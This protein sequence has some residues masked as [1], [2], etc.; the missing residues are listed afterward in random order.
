MLALGFSQHSRLVKA[1]VEVRVQM[2]GLMRK[3]RTERSAIG[4]EA[5]VP[6]VY[7][8]AVGDR[9]GD[10]LVGVGG[11]VLLNLSPISPTRS[12]ASVS[13]RALAVGVLVVHEGQYG[14]FHVAVVRR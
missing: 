7:I 5:S 6:V 3:N 13:E 14:L 10:G 12:G 2:V 4:R 11:D 1:V 8:L 9:G